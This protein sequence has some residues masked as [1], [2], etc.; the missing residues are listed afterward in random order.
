MTTRTEPFKHD[1]DPSERYCPKC[2]GLNSAVHDTS[3]VGLNASSNPSELLL[4]GP[5]SE[6][7]EEMDHTRDVNHVLLSIVAW[8]LFEGL[9]A[10]RNI[11]GVKR[12][13]CWLF[14]PL[15]RKVRGTR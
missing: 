8:N 15:E 7:D 9:G 4:T 11:F 13:I 1:S 12:S 2:G 6:C 5:A 3:G 10:I 14:V